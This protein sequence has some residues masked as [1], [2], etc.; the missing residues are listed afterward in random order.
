MGRGHFSPER[1]FFLISSVSKRY[2]LR[3]R[4]ARRCHGVGGQSSSAT[5]GT[6]RVMCGKS[7][8]EGQLLGCSLT[9]V[10]R[11]E[12]HSKRCC[13]LMASFWRTKLLTDFAA[14]NASRAS[15]GVTISPG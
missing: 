4:N 13:L 6:N 14:F 5:G 8:E 2:E 11:G 10:D 7:F 1:S 15:A 9:I 12:H 3:V